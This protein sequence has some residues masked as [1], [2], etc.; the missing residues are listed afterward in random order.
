MDV[1]EHPPLFSLAPTIPDHVTYTWVVMILLTVV[2]FLASRNV[3]LVPA[4][5]IGEAVPP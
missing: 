5:R 3:G 4:S 1:I 2:A